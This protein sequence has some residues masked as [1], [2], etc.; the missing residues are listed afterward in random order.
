[1]MAAF[2]IIFTSLAAFV[3]GAASTHRRSGSSAPEGHRSPPGR[4]KVKPYLRVVNG[5]KPDKV[6]G[7]W[8]GN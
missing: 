1:M 2:G 6:H 8:R 7:H 3:A 5:G 4:H